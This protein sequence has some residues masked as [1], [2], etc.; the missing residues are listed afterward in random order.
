MPWKKQA[1]Q[2][3]QIMQTVKARPSSG[4]R[5]DMSLARRPAPVLYRWET[6]DMLQAASGVAIATLV[7]NMSTEHLGRAIR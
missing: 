6:S 1:T 7:C 2:G 3:C 4:T 5:A